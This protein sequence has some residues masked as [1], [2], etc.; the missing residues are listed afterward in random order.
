[1]NFVSVI[2]IWQVLTGFCESERSSAKCRLMCQ[3]NSQCSRFVTNN[4]TFVNIL[5]FISGR[6]LCTTAVS[7]IFIVD[8]YSKHTS[9]VVWSFDWFFVKLFLEPKTDQFAVIGD[10][11]DIHFITMIMYYTVS[12]IYFTLIL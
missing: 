4:Q 10:A 5:P 12:N 6:N 8:I 9:E 2:S 3:S 11:A 1:M 7:F